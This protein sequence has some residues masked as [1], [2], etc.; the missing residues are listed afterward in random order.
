MSSKLKEIG[1]ATL[2][3]GIGKF[4]PQVIGFFLIPLYTMYLT[5]EDYGIVELATAFGAFSLILMRLALP[6]SVSRFY[7]EHKEG[8][9]LRDYITTIYWSLLAISVG[10]AALIYIVSYFFLHKLV[11]GLPLWPFVGVVLLADIFSA[12]SE[13]QKRLLQARKQS[14]YS[15]KLSI[16][17]SLVGIITAIVLV[18]GFDL[19][20]LGI[21]GASLMGST[22]FFIQAQFY[23]RKDMG[24]NFSFKLLTPSFKYALNILPSHFV[25]PFGN[26]LSRSL[27]SGFSSLAAVGLYSL[28]MRFI[29]PLYLISEAFNTAFSPIYFE[30]RKKDEPE[31]YKKLEDACKKIWLVAIF[32]FVAASALTPSLIHLITPE[33]YHPAAELIPFMAISF[34]PT[35]LTVMYSNE[36]YYSKKTAWVSVIAVTRFVSNLAIALLFIEQWGYYALILAKFIENIIIMLFSVFISRKMFN[37]NPNVPLIIKSGLLGLVLVAVS[38]LFANYQPNSYLQ[39]G[40]G[41]ALVAAFAGLL[42]VT[43]MASIDTLKNYIKSKRL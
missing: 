17:T 8:P 19:G 24:G 27:L 12:N 15:A 4:L 36:M 21:V 18:V 1:G 7:Y 6:G 20:A 32:M 31:G 3:Y 2:N 37:F 33:R 29:T 40:F 38:V 26:L 43:R 30:A 22:I 28:A 9:E 42:V 41:L 16:V 39:L 23:L 34:L 25:T 10:M 5:P 11:P 13:I 14:A 35:V